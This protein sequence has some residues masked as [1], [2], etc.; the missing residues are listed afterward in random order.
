MVA[1]TIVVL[2][3]VAMTLPALPQPPQQTRYTL[4]TKQVAAVVVRSF[5]ETGIA[6]TDQQISLPARVVAT[7]QIPTLDVSSVEVLSDYVFE[8]HSKAR[9]KIRLTCRIASVC[10]PFYAI[11]IWPEGLSIP[12][13]VPS[14][15][16]SHPARVSKPMPEITMQAGTHATLVMDDER[17]HI[18]LTVVSLESGSA[19][20]KIRVASP[21]HKQIYIAE[22]ISA[23]LLKG[24][25]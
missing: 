11:V 13:G 9:S 14:V 12:S 19:G 22:I 21:D 1:K 3:M 15:L 8:G 5:L 2:L 17:A 23:N 16:S 18:Q 20:H 4:T 24:S 25:F 6:L 10:L 7:E